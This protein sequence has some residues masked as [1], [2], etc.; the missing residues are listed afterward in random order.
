MVEYIL[1][2]HNEIFLTGIK[3]NG[4]L[5]YFFHLIYSVIKY[6]KRFDNLFFLMII[7]HFCH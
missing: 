5:L 4:T 6:Y 2:K 3:Y 7:D 1:E